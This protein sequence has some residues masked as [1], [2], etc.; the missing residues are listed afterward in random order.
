MI[1]VY[2]YID[3]RRFLKD[4][5][6]EQKKKRPSFSYR[7]FNR[8]AG[9]KS[10]GFLKL[11]MDKKRN[12]A[13]DGIRKI[14]RGFKMSENEE[15]YFEL[16]VKFNQADSNETKDR[17]FRELSQNKK[18]LAA[19]P[20]ASSQ[21]RLFSRWY[22]VAV[23]EAARIETNE[24]KNLAWFQRVVHPAVSIKH[25]KT[26]VRELIQLG[27][28]AKGKKG[29]FRRL[30]GMIA[31]EDEVRSIAVAN[32]HDQMCQMAMR[33]VMKDDAKD[34]EF[35]ALTIVSSGKSFQRAK[36]EIQKFRKKLHSILEQED[37]QPKTFVAHLNLQLFK[38]SKD[39]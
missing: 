34:R 22:Y 25:I 2:D 14:S 16:L 32:F 33:S 13:D 5:F 26:A 17:Y 1:S 38:L 12:L 11:V 23:L 35:S 3:Y 10:S 7:V 31:T 37:E 19:K 8:Q 30:E 21:Y 6:S 9:I 29:G 28:L 27:L 4:R 15:R 18:F 39:G 36:K 20:L 24:E